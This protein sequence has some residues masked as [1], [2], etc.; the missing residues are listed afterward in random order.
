MGGADK[1][2]ALTRFHVLEFDDL[3][4]LTVHLKRKAVLEIA[5]YYHNIDSSKKDITTFNIIVTVYF[6]ATFCFLQDLFS[7]FF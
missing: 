1:S 3:H 2:R 7:I 4:D 6:T 5:G